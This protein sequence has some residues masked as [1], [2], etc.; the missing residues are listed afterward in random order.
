MERM[1]CDLMSGLSDRGVETV[2]FCTDG[3]GELY[4]SAP[5]LAKDCGYRKP[6]FLVIDWGLV[7]RM[8]R[9]VR[10]QRVLLLHAH[11]HAPTLYCGLVSI[12]TGVPMVVTRHGQGHSSTRRVLLTR[13]LGMRAKAVVLVSENAKQVAIKNS[14]ASIENSMVLHNGIDTKRFQ[15]AKTEDRETCRVKLGIPRDAIVIGSVGRL[16]PEKN[17]SLLVRAFARL[18]NSDSLSVIGNSGREGVSRPLFP[19]N[20]QQP[21]TN[22]AAPGGFFLLLVGDGPDR[23]VIEAE[24]ARHNLQDCCHITGMQSEV[25][26]WLQ[27]MDIFCLSSDT[28]GLSISLLEAGACGLP[29]VVTDAG[30]NREIV[31]DGVS[32][33][34]VP[35]KDEAAL[36]AGFEQLASDAA[37]RHTMGSAARKIVEDRFSR[38][39]MVEGYMKVYERAVAG[40]KGD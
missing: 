21:I 10:D 19:P 26:P 13:L 29:S 30:G 39:A 15:S 4:E 5:A 35:M 27:A 31:K 2:L 12:L 8:A 36:A 20:N 9:F 11:N 34:V 25:L 14:S 3:K 38:D 22:N 33:L 6:R 37:M 1:V 7:F 32:G 18:V 40:R 17:Y 23:S 16:S 28:E 24:I